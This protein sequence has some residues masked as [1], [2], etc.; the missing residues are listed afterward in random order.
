MRGELEISDV[1]NHY[2]KRG[3]IRYAILKEIWTD[4]GTPGSYRLV[5]E[6]VIQEGR[7]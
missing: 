4:A 3:A 1:S 7:N 5:N 2:I 6:W